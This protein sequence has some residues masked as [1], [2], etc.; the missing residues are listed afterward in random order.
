LRRWLRSAERLS[1]RA[2][3]FGSVQVKTP[4][5]R[6]SALLCLVTS[7]DVRD[8]PRHLGAG[9]R[10]ELERDGRVGDR[11]TIDIGQ[12]GAVVGRGE[13]DECVHADDRLKPVRDLL[14]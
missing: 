3:R 9:G 10:L 2:I 8:A 1:E 7:P 11:G 6:S 14:A 12:C 13:T 4:G 5:S